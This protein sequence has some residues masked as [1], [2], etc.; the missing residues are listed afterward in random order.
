MY[1]GGDSIKGFR[2]LF[3]DIILVGKE[4]MFVL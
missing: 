1:Y 2:L 3:M 4:T